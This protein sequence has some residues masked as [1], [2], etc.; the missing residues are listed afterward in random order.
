MLEVLTGSREVRL[1]SMEA[2]HK[3]PAL[4]HLVLEDFPFPKIGAFPQMP[5]LQ[6]LCID[7]WTNLQDPGECMYLIITY[8]LHHLYPNPG[9]LTTSI[10]KLNELSI[11]SG[12]LQRIPVES[13]NSTYL[14][15]LKLD[16]NP[17]IRE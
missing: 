17:D 5:S 1:F 7:R 13:L 6:R 2:F 12:D 11:T 8:S 15:I 3:L 10:P 16:N 4:T 9:H 14:E